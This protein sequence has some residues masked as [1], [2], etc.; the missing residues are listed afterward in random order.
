MDFKSTLLGAGL[1]TMGFLAGSSTGS[2]PAQDQEPGHEHCGPWHV[3]HS[4]ARLGAGPGDQGFYAIRY[5]S[6]TGEAWVLSAV[7]QAD[8]DKWYKLPEESKVTGE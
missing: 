8:D 6:E 5:N 2:L 1:L 3:E 7:R 4:D